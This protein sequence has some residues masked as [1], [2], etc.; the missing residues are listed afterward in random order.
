MKKT[1]VKETFFIIT[2][3]HRSPGFQGYN[4]HQGA[5]KVPGL[6]FFPSNIE[7]G[8]S[9]L[10]HGFSNV[11]AIKESELIFKYILMYSQAIQLFLIA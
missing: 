8:V 11:W 4:T 9:L 5:S 7:P 6:S 2:E 3:R 1:N 10:N